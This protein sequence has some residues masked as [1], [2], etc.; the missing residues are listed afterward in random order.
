ML[1]WFLNPIQYPLI[2][3]VQLPFPSAELRS[4]GFIDK[5]GKYVI[6]PQ[7]NSGGTFKNGIAT[8]CYG[9]GASCI[10]RVTI[11]RKGNLIAPETETKEFVPPP[12]KVKR[13]PDGSSEFICC[14][15]LSDGIA[16]QTL[17]LNKYVAEKSGS[18]TVY[19]VVH[20]EERLKLLNKSGET[21]KDL[22]GVRVRNGDKFSDGLLPVEIE[23]KIGYIDT[24]GTLIIKKQ[25]DNGFSFKDGLACVVKRSR[26]GQLCGYIDKTGTIV[27]PYTYGSPR[28]FQNERALVSLPNGR[29]GF[30]DKAGKVVV[31]APYRTN[32]HKFSEGMATFENRDGAG[33][34]DKNGKIICRLKANRIGN[35]SEGLCAA[36]TGAK[37][38]FVDKNGTWVI[39]PKYRYASDFSESVAAVCEFDDKRLQQQVAEVD[40][41]KK[42]AVHRNPGER[43]V[44][45]GFDYDISLEGHQN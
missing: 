18:Q 17:T 23:K 19:R 9:S 27:I 13:L 35:F 11:N 7:F 45:A 3:D 31:S 14:G 21:I 42:S 39:A 20:T 26:T 16:V 44:Q 15:E 30:I 2:I 33:F 29:T 6:A 41:F 25:F 10:K 36:R 22:P 32:Y 5:Q 1:N 40:A 34:I 4:W 12:P 43:P 24:R 37:V 38:G 28:D 8:I